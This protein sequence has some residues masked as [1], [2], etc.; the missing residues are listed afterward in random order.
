MADARAEA[1]NRRLVERL[2]GSGALHEPRVREALLAVPR[3]DFLPGLDLEQVYED[4]AILTRT[5]EAGIPISSSSQP[6]IM[7]L[8]LEQLGVAPGHRVL[9]VGAGTGYNAALLAR[10]AGPAGAVTTIEID[11]ELGAAAR[12]HLAAAGA[13][14]V[15]TVIGDG[16]AGHPP[17]APYDRIMVTAGGRDI[18]RAWY[19][20]LAEGGR[21][22]LPLALAGPSHLAL[23]FTHGPGCL[24]AVGAAPCGFMPLRGELA[25]SLPPAAALGPGQDTGRRLPGALRGTTFESWLALSEPGYFRAGEPDGGTEFGLLDGAGAAVLRETGGGLGLWR[26]GTGDGAGGRLLAALHRWQ[27]SPPGYDR[28]RVTARPTGAP[29]PSPPP[30]GE[31]FVRPQFSFEIEWP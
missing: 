21:L 30:A 15:V 24:V 10:L 13:G 18:A 4:R 2:A 31:V 28:L 17:A 9:E 23:A 12:A 29:P 26:H 11:P 22:V 25:A 27:A 8:M 5:D 7:A 6:A 1:L 3:H 16:A 14:Q 20:Q 19:E